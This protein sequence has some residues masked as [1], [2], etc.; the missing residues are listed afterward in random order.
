MEPA[1]EEAQ[2]PHMQQPQH[3]QKERQKSVPVSLFN[4][5]TISPRNFS[6]NPTTAAS[7]T[8]SESNDYNITSAAVASGAAVEQS[9]HSD[10]E[11][12]PWIAPSMSTAISGVTPPY[13]RH[14]RSV[15]LASQTSLE[16]ATA[17]RRSLIR[18]EDHTEDPA[19]E[20]S[21][22]LWA[23]SVLIEDYIVVKGG[24]SGIG[25]YVVWICKI[26]TLEG[27]LVVV[28]MRYSQFDDLRSKLA[29]AFPHAK[30]ALPQLP[31][32]SAIFKFSPKFL[33]RR[34][35][36]LEYFLNCVLLN[37][38]FSGSPILKEVLFSHVG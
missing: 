18:L 2:P 15:S 7:T 8:T 9:P 10:E 24:R 23:R 6:T 30:S 1:N 22:G 11:P 38:E 32:K 26:Q 3:N 16:V 35:V 21:Q 13:W 12:P 34:R 20:T 27:G 17:Q 36:G 29:T 33:E 25:A 14:H 19:S 28:R 4:N 37:P 5:T 31:P